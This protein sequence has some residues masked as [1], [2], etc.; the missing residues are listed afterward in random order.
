VLDREFS[1]GQDAGSGTRETVQF[2]TLSRFFRYATVR[3]LSIWCGM[4]ISRAGRR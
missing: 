2:G 1:F 3:N 4:K